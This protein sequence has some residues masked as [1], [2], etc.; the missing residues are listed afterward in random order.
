MKT[1]WPCDFDLNGLPEGCRII[2][3]HL[4]AD[5]EDNDEDEILVELPN[6]ISIDAG[7]YGGD[8]FMV[9]VIPQCDIG[10]YPIEKSYF[11]MPEHVAEQVVR[12][13]NKWNSP[14]FKALSE[15]LLADKLRKYED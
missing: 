9:A 2:S 8:M 1:E 15:M 5:V 14:D 12:L 4:D 10:W 3:N 7:F 6:G 13:A 11:F